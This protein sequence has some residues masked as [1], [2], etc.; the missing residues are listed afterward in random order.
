MGLT[1]NGL[2]GGLNVPS[3]LGQ[4]MALE[5]RPQTLLFDR[6]GSVQRVAAAYRD[7][8]SKFLALLTAANALTTSSTWSATT[9]AASDPSVTVR[10][11]STAQPG[12]LTFNVTQAAAA[13]AVIST[14]AGWASTTAAYGAPSIT[15]YDGTGTITKGTITIGG[16]GTLADAAAAINT[17][18]FGLTA[19]IVQVAGSAYQLQV[20]S[21]TTGASSAF[22]LGAGFGVVTAGAD[23]KATVGTGPAAYTATSSSNAFTG[24]M[25]GVTITVSKPVTGV[26]VTVASDANGVATKMQALVDAANSALSSIASH[27][28]TSRGTTAALS[29]NYTLYDLAQRVLTAVSSAVGT[30]GSAAQAGLQLTKDSKITFDKAAFAAQLTANPALTQRLVNGT[31][32]TP[33][34]AARLATVATAATNSVTGTLVTLAN[35]EDMLAKGLQNQIDAWTYRL[36]GRQDQLTNR[37]TSL[38]TILATIQNQQ[39]WLSGLIATAYASKGPVQGPR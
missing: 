11:D 16:A 15:V 33:G 26:T 22:S 18:S 4:L 3:V 5:S 38:Q 39:S 14:G 1:V 23:A 29:G 13:H 31:A 35:G 21:K 36:A 17:S 27:T 24:L 25:P 6:L 19:S 28:D 12:T 20:T 7:V 32:T 10:S 9:A 37:F 8:N 2:V 30:D 34:V